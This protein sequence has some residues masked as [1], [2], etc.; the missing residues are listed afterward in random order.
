MIRK[1]KNCGVEFVPQTEECYLCASCYEKAMSDNAHRRVKCWQCGKEF[2]GFIRSRYCP[3]CTV[4]RRRERDRKRRR[5]GTK[6]KLGSIDHCEICGK[7]YIVNSGLQRYCK[8]CAEIA[9]TEWARDRHAEY[10]RS[11]GKERRD[12]NRTRL[13]TDAAVCPVCGKTFTASPDNPHYCSPECAEMAAGRS[14][15]Y[16][17]INREPLAGGLNS[18]NKTG[19]RG[20]FFSKRYNKF[21]VRITVNGVRRWVGYYDALDDAVKARHDAESLHYGKT[22]EA[23]RKKKTKGDTIEESN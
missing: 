6:R 21:V 18:R 15:E 4:E 12:E 13:K 1:C 10:Y 7:E 9:K 17:V 11:G 19:V 14:D 23:S 8:D 3:D 16:R 20:V 2:D 5:E 22:S